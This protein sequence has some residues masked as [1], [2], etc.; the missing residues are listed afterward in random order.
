MSIMSRCRVQCPRV[1]KYMAKSCK[2]NDKSTCIQYYGAS[3]VS[4]NKAWLESFKPY[5]DKYCM[6]SFFLIHPL[7]SVVH[8]VTFFISWL[9]NTRIQPSCFSFSPYSIKICAQYF[10]QSD[11]S[12]KPRI[13]VNGFIVESCPE[14]KINLCPF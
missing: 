12:S 5:F 8:P 9:Y 1:L 13:T 6:K 14:N 7:L 4:Q 11:I 10:G 2:R 3:K